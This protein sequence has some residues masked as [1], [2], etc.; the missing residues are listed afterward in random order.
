MSEC[1]LCSIKPDGYSIGWNIGRV[2]G[3][4]LFHAHLHVIP[5]FSKEP[6][7]GRGIRSWLKSAENKWEE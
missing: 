1:I 6:F 3:Q 7:A 4:V 5:R 2:A